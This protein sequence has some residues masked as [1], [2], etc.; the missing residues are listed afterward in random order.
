MGYSLPLLPPDQSC[1]VSNI[2][3]MAKKNC[4]RLGCILQSALPKRGKLVMQLVRRE[5]QGHTFEN[6]G[7]AFLDKQ[8][9]EGKSPATLSKTEYHLKLANK[10][11]GRK[12]ISEITSPMVLRC[13]RKVEAK[14]NYETAHRLR[15]RIGSIFRYVVATRAQRAKVG[16]KK[17]ASE[18]DSELQ[19]FLNFVLSQYVSEGVGELDSSK[20]PE[21]LELRYKGV[22]DATEHLGNVRDIRKAF[23]GFQRHLY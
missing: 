23:V 11:F 3:W 14:G 18:Y 16:E 21:L 6:V 13:L 1:G 7:A 8:R 5:S 10:D 22:N 17:I 2:A 20:L 12:P 19:V 9:N 4:C 15:A